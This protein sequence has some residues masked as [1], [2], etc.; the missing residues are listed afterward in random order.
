MSNKIETF[1]KVGTRHGGSDGYGNGIL[2]RSEKF[3]S[4]DDLIK[5]YKEMNMY[6]YEDYMII[7]CFG[8]KQD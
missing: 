8:V 2:L 6:K 5:H 4:V 7:Q 1:Y 3:K